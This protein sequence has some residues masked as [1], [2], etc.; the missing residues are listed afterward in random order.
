[1]NEN[2]VQILAING[3]PRK[4]GNT[5]ILLEEAI[6]GANKVPKAKIEVVRFSFGDHKIGHCIGCLKCMESRMCILR[7]DFSLFTERWLAAD[8]V[9]YALPVY[10]R[11]CPSGLKAALDRLGQSFLGKYNRRIPRFCKASGVIVHGGSRYGGQEL[12]ANDILEHILLMRCIPVA[13]EAPEAK[14]GVIGHAPNWDKGSIVSDQNAL[15][16]SRN[17]GL[18]VTEMALALRIGLLGIQELCMPGYDL[19]GGYA[20]EDNDV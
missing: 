1:M 4:H 2:T 11:G 13:G 12:A 19:F 5:E 16:A 20:K 14:V 7:D 6:R 9:L 8:V 10:H 15:T 17:L 18:R 3:S